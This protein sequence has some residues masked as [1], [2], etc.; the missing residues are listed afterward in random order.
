MSDLFTDRKLKKEL[1][2]FDKKRV[3]EALPLTVQEI[4]LP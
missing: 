4:P 3:E 1:D 2:D